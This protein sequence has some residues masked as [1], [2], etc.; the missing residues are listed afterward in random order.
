MIKQAPVH[1]FNAPL[2]SLH[3]DGPACE[4]NI[5]KEV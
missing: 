4:L 5:L 2:N 1:I 3:F